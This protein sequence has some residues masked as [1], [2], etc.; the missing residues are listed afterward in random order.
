LQQP[1]VAPK[2]HRPFDSSPS[3]HP[4][5]SL[6]A[7]SL[8]PLP[9]P[10]S[11]ERYT[12]R[13]NKIMAGEPDFVPLSPHGSDLWKAVSDGK[14][15]CRFLNKCQPGT[16]DEAVFNKKLSGPMAKL[17]AV[18]GVNPW[19]NTETLNAFIESSKFIGLELGAVGATGA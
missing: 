1:P 4:L 18:N 14:W 5:L 3:P 16:I 10:V 9:T 15:L 8:P 12:T 11:Q 17:E 7:S 6:R 2:P 19:A 13:I